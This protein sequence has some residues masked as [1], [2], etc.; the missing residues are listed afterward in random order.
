[1]NVNKIGFN[2]FKAFGEK[3]LTFTKKPITLVYGPNSIGKSSFLHSQLYLEYL[4]NVGINIDLMKT[5]FA[6]DSLDLNGFGNFIHKH[7][8]N[9]ELKYEYHLQD[10]NAIAE[11]LS[12]NYLK[13]KELDDKGFFK[14]KTN[15]ALLEN[16]LGIYDEKSISTFKSKIAYSNIKQKLSA[17]NEVNKNVKSQ[18]INIMRENFEQ[19]SNIIIKSAY[20]AYK[21]SGNINWQY[22]NDTKEDFQKYKVLFENEITKLENTE[23]LLE[24]AIVLTQLNHP[25]E[26]YDQLE[27]FQ[28]LLN[29]ST[30][31]L[32]ITLSMEEKGLKTFLDYY[33]D[34]DQLFSMNEKIFN[35]NDNHPLIGYLKNKEAKYLQKIREQ[36][37]EKKDSIIEFYENEV[38]VPSK[39][40]G[41]SMVSQFFTNFLDIFSDFLYAK[42]FVSSINIL[43]SKAL[44]FLNNVD[45]QKTV[46]YFSPLRFYPERWDLNEKVKTKTDNR[47]NVND[48][49]HFTMGMLKNMNSI[50]YKKPFLYLNINFWRT[51]LRSQSFYDGINNLLPE[52]MKLTPVGASTA[53][54]FW[55]KLIHSQSLQN[56]LNSWFLDESKLKSTYKVYTREYE[57]EYSFVV[58]LFRKVFAIKPVV[59]KELYFL[60]LRSNTEVSP[61]DMG[62][63]ISQMLPI[64]LAS[65]D[66]EETKIV[67]EQPE[68]H[69]H[70]A[71]QAE[72]ADEFIRSYKEND[73]EFMI[74]THSEHL[75]LRIM[76]RMRYTAED[77]QDRDKTLDLTPDD[78]CLLYVDVHKGKTFIRELKLDK[79]GS[80]LSRWP[81][82]FFEESY[83]EMFS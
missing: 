75:L 76:K 11:L 41:Y 19:S 42:T 64:L 66:S 43:K 39:I 71:V 33:I 81:S 1:M 9:R 2:N 15:I 29:I 79:D 32:S 65:L 4:R 23:D 45:N 78:V 73:N 82:G 21:K 13:I 74:E 56:K 63:G 25:E 44:S 14:I 38:F 57:V 68:L 30:I 22:E 31:R 83:N 58:N 67:I 51:I 53:Q 54:K 12:N 46:Q 80:L 52:S 60:D 35:I 55:S 20:I 47:Q 10:G 6:G 16:K 3:M 37:E 69:L 17:L 61:R 50:F 36:S 34:N 72:L 62:L 8:I 49:Q 28:Y 59:E 7:E 48:Q 77:K 5:N 18:D 40:F 24:K 27:F 70:P 26:I